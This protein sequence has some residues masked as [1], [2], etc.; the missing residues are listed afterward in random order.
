M[1][2]QLWLK[3]TQQQEQPQP[4]CLAL[5]ELQI[6]QKKKNQMLDRCQ[7]GVTRNFK[8]QL[9]QPQKSQVFAAK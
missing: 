9:C 6:W 4:L 8:F 7:T 2:D 1:D 5:Q 3:T